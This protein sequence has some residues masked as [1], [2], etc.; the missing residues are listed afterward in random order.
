MPKD[1]CLRLY[2]LSHLSYLPSEYNVSSSRYKAL[3]FPSR[4]V[5]H[6]GR[7]TVLDS[8]SSYNVHGSNTVVLCLLIMLFQAWV[9]CICPSIRPVV[10]GHDVFRTDKTVCYSLSIHGVDFIASICI[11]PFMMTFLAWVIVWCTISPVL[12]GLSFVTLVF[13]LQFF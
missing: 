12:V 7:N 3:Y 5:I 9:N 6:I 1:F 10:N 2:L 11:W 13:P 4:Y 8:P